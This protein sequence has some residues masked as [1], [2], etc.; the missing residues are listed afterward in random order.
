MCAKKSKPGNASQFGSLIYR[1]RWGL[2]AIL[3][4]GVVAVGW[5]MAWNRVSDHVLTGDDYRVTPERISISAVPPWI[6]CDLKAEVM[7]DASLERTLSLL[8]D[9]LTKRLANAFS[10][11]PWVSRVERVSK[12]HPARVEVHLVYRRPVAMVEVSGG[13]LPIDEDGILL[14]SADFSPAEAKQYPRISRVESHPAGPVGANW[15]DAN[16]LGGA[17]IA[18]ILAERWKKLRLYR[19]LAPVHMIA[20]EYVDRY[21]YELTTH[22]GT[23]LL[24]GRSPGNE[25][26]GEPKA[27]EKVARLEEILQ[28][29]GSLDGR[30][31]PRIIDLR[32][33]T[34]LTRT[35]VKKLPASGAQ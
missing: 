2:V 33:S 20:D 9:D 3:F 26:A 32:T 35:A 18:S 10:L 27:G 22:A 15:G 19:I 5:N 11:H 29:D 34:A 24:W 8:D 13:L 25:P 4:A 31:G 12:H 21:T 7:R 23:R 30:E 17:R 14:P 16:V 1:G 28:R 6:H